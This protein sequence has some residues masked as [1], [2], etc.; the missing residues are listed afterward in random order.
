[1]RSVRAGSPIGSP[2]SRRKKSLIVLDACE[3][4][5]SEAFRGGDRAHETVLAQLEHATGRNTIAAAP[6]GKA[7]YEGYR[8]HGVLTYAILEALHRPS[9]APADPIS[10]FGIAQQVSLQ[11][12]AITQRAFGVRQQPRFRPTGDDFSLGFRQAVLLDAPVTM[13]TRLTHY[14]RRALPVFK[15]AGGRGGVVLQLKRD[16]PVT[17]VKIERGWAHIAR[18]SKAL[19]Y[20]QERGL[21]E[22]AQ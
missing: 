13:P 11:V 2:G 8:G 21:Q 10:V 18:D 5:A 9:G 19:G 20:V 17:V 22:F 16:T 1:M 15:E 6:A 3:S 4:G 7:A 14:T 12:P